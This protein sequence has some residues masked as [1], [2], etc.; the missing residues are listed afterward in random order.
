MMNLG[1][2]ERMNTCLS[3]QTEINLFS[4]SHSRRDR[5]LRSHDADSMESFVFG[6]ALAEWSQPAVLCG[7]KVGGVVKPLN[8]DRYIYRGLG[9]S[10]HEIWW[11][12]VH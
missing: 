10:F 11:K 7:A 1:I 2:V 8:Y 3:P 4:C 12:F 5:P 9:K 6:D